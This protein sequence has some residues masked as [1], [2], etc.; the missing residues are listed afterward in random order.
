MNI[1]IQ[2]AA[3]K[4]PNAGYLV[5][6]DGR[7]VVFV[8][9]PTLASVSKNQIYAM[10]DD[11]ANGL[12]W[13]EILSEYNSKEENPFNLLPAWKLYSNPSYAALVE[14]YGI[15]KVYILS[16]GWGLIKASFLTPYYDI[17]FSQSAEKHKKREKRVHYQDFVQLNL[18]SKEDLFFFGGK[19]YLPLLCQLTRPYKGKRYIFYNA[20]VPPDVQGCHLI[21]YET[22][23]RTNWHYE[24][25]QS[26]ISG[27]VGLESDRYQAISTNTNHKEQA[28]T[29]HNTLKTDITVKVA[30][31]GSKYEPLAEFLRNQAAGARSVSLSFKEIE[32]LIGA[33][34]PSSAYRHRAWWANEQA[35]NSHSHAKAW[36]SA[37]FR[38]ENVSQKQHAGSI[39]FA[40]R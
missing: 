26:F 5:S 23:T 25:V 14:R 28:A 27:K 4:S 8:A 13:R 36:L 20:K 24:C 6:K 32:K 37:G 33:K 2:C 40:R 39:V 18:D 10:P 7:S 11:R 12:T 16:A 31:M 35:S 30:R 38:V 9:N 1:V 3:S 22:K 21:R 19:D 15:D 29:K 34:L 17:T